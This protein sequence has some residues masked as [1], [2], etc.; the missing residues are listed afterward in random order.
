MLGAQQPETTSLP[1]ALS[2]TQLLPLP[3][4]HL[5]AQLLAPHLQQSQAAG[6]GESSKRL[7]LPPLPPPLPPP[8]APH[9]CHPGRRHRWLTSS[10]VDLSSLASLMAR[11]VRAA[12]RG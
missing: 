7:P 10:L 12:R 11:T 6:L 2:P 3:C 9:C 5:S 4:T 8:A 1:F